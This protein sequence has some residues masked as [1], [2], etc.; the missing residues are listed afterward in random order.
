MLIKVVVYPQK[1]LTYIYFWKTVYGGGGGGGGGMQ[2]KVQPSDL[3]NEIS[4]MNTFLNLHFEFFFLDPLQELLN[5]I[6]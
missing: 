1:Y 3:L 4:L 2:L 5:V 6:A